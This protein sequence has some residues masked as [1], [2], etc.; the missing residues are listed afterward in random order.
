MVWKVYL[1]KHVKIKAVKKE[2]GYFRTGKDKERWRGVQKKRQDPH[3]EARAAQEYWAH[4]HY[5]PLAV[6]WV[7]AEEEE[8]QFLGKQWHQQGTIHGLYNSPEASQKGSVAWQ[9]WKKQ[10]GDHQPACSEQEAPPKTLYPG[11][12]LP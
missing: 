11:V 1:N 10:Q 12:R 7:Q 9:A 6:R 3:K 5:F 4:A 2:T 8:S